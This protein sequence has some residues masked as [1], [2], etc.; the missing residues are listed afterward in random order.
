MRDWLTKHSQF[1]GREASRLRDFL[2]SDL[3]D[4]SGGRL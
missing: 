1:K 2:A 3:G 4:V